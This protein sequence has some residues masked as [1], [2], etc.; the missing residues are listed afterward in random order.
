MESLRQGIITLVVLDPIAIL[1][2]KLTKRNI[3]AIG[4]YS[5]NDGL[6]SVTIFNSFDTDYCPLIEQ[7]MGARSGKY[8]ISEFQEQLNSNYIRI[9]NF[10][11]FNQD[12]SLEKK[13]GEYLLH[14][15]RQ[16]EN[17]KAV[18]NALL[19]DITI[20]TGNTILEVIL[21]QI[22]NEAI[23]VEFIPPTE[24]FTLA[25]Q[26]ESNGQRIQKI[27]FDSKIIKYFNAYCEIKSKSSYDENVE[28]NYETNELI[29]YIT[30]LGDL[31]S[32]GFNEG[33]IKFDMV[34]K[35]IRGINTILSTLGRPSIILPST[36][37]RIIKITDI[38]FTL[39]NMNQES[40]IIF[41][42]FRRFIT[43]IINMI[44]N[45][46]S[47]E[48]II[49]PEISEDETEKRNSGENQDSLTGISSEG[50]TKMTE[51]DESSIYTRD[52]S[53]KID[54]RNLVRIYNMLAKRFDEEII[55]SVMKSEIHQAL[56]YT[57]AENN[58]VISHT[59]IPL[60]EP[61]FHIFSQSELPQF[62]VILQELAN[63]DPKYAIFL[64]SLLRYM[65]TRKDDKV[66]T[67]TS[68]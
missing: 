33:L 23:V 6:I 59:E 22:L 66:S 8:T 50:V 20:D 17:E 18:I 28:L 4:I 30:S 29:N 34:Q 46:S 38:K 61:N 12:F 24:F 54:L 43:G 52:Q 3:Y 45:H 32:K 13:I 67:T 60:L 35:I 41:A 48:K 64:N 63:Q 9:A 25:F 10:Y 49:T 39:P 7:G 55:E 11:E 2:K 68:S 40:Q 31:L 62:L 15:N 53:I 57:S 26:Y 16:F 27:N 42:D 14:N 58:I 1:L 21:T 65:S 51:K 37:T 36:S 44:E 19:K 47:K 56:I 5:Q